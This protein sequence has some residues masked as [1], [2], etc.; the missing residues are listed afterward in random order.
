MTY[1]SIRNTAVLVLGMHRS[2][3]SSVAG[4]LRRLGVDLGSNLMSAQADNPTGFFE[5]ND[6]VRLH[7]Q[8]FRIFGT[9]WDDPCCLPAGWEADPRLAPVRKCLVDIIVRDFARCSLW[10]LKD[11]RLCRLL[12][13]WLDLFDQLE[14]EAKV[15]LVIRDP[16]HVSASLYERNRIGA[17]QASMLW[18]SHVLSSERYSRSL[19]RM[20]IVYDDLLSNW[21]P[22]V[23]RL[24]EMLAIDTLALSQD[25]L[26]D[27]SSFLSDDLRHHRDVVMPTLHAPQNK[28]VKAV[29][30]A[31]VSWR[32][33]AIS[34][35]DALSR[36]N[37]EL[38][39]AQRA[40]SPV[41]TYHRLRAQRDLD[42]KGKSRR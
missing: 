21:E 13:L 10:G 30:G 16:A 40:A 6:V 33:Q 37:D 14:I 17:E 35:I 12:P 9:T 7:E 5:H 38:D 11:P 15:V 8:I 24:C 20:V 28:H 18:L 3:T 27:V 19:A 2:G 39:Y 25:V 41:A 4:V 26:D 34:P 29:Y 32:H 1:A 31:V 36:A 23:K 42:R 22:E